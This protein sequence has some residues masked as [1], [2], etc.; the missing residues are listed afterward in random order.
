MDKKS[1][2]HYKLIQNHLYEDIYENDP[3]GAIDFT[4]TY[5]EV[6][7]PRNVFRKIFY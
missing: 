7:M 3:F 2:E 1:D 5:G 4:Y 6:I